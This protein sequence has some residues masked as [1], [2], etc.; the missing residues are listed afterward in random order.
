MIRCDGGGPTLANSTGACCNI[1]HDVQKSQPFLSN[2]KQA[3]QHLC[4]F[5]Q[6]PTGPLFVQ[7]SVGL[8]GTSATKLGPDAQA[9]QNAN[10]GSPKMQFFELMPCGKSQSDISAILINRRKRYGLN[11]RLT[12]FPVAAALNMLMRDRTLGPIDRVADTIQS[13]NNQK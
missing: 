2:N 7:Q 5:K 11:S 3:E 13:E 8:L 1:V 10:A 4:K 9:K 12:S 6:E